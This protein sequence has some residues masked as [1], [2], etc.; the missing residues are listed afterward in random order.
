MGEEQDKPLFFKIS[1][2]SFFFRLYIY[3]MTLKKKEL[4]STLI[5][6]VR[7]EDIM[8]LHLGKMTLK[9]L[10]EWFGLKPETLGKS[11]S[12]AKNK[13]LEILKAYADY[14]MEE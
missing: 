6:F 4:L 12:A 2:S 8:E 1:K 13:K 3:Y 10:S 14:H 5:K 11:G 7:K 9:E